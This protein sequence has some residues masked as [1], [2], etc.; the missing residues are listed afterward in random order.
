MI[1]VFAALA[2]LVAMGSAR[3][4]Q[5]PR[6]ELV[7]VVRAVGADPRGPAWSLPEVQAEAARLL[8]PAGIDLR[9]R[10]D[11]PL[12]LDRGA[13][14]LDGN[15]RLD[16]WMDE[17]PLQASPEETAL[18]HR[19]RDLGMV[20]PQIALFQDSVRLGW[21]IRSPVRAGDTLLRLA[22]SSPLPWRDR[23]GRTVRYALEGP[24]GERGE[25]FSISDYLPAGLRVQADGVR[26][27]WKRDHPA[28]DLV[29]RP[30]GG[31]PPFGSTDRQDPSA[32]SIVFLEPGAMG[33]ALRCARVVVH[34]L[35]HALGLSDVAA[36]DNLMSA[37]LHMDVETPSLTPEQ[38]AIMV[39]RLDSLRDGRRGSRRGGNGTK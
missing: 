14:D 17:G 34:E 12:E 23:S 28:S 3:P 35:C 15:R 32:P 13:W 1:P 22:S 33:D 9:L 27:G 29:V 25:A 16:L 18:R 2:S 10:V 36:Q 24:R 8:R 20:F 4:L 37:V 26:G 5:E 7:A 38:A 30:H 21:P 6:R 11:A 19:L 31:V 39:R